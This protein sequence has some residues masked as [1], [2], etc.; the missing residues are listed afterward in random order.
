MELL[1]RGF[2]RVVRGLDDAD[3]LIKRLPELE[4]SALSNPS[5]ITEQDRLRILDLPDRATQE[6]NIAASSTFT[7]SDL[8]KRAIYV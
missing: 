8:L 3:E 1:I 6:A 5:S 4:Q 2:M 7:K